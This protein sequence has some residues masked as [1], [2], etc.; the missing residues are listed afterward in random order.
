MDGSIYCY[1]RGA[2]CNAAPKNEPSMGYHTDAMAV[3][4][5]FNLVKYLRNTD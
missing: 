3:I 5:V 1:C 2:Y 4:I